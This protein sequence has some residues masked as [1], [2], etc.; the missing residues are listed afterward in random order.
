MSPVIV[1]LLMSRMLLNYN[2]SVV[3]LSIDDDGQG[4]V[5]DGKDSGLGLRSMQERAE[6]L[7]GK[8]TIESA[9][10]QGTRLMSTVPVNSSKEVDTE[11]L[12]WINL[13]R[14]YWLTIMRL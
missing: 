10:G 7:G 3:R 4:F 11:V 2:Q 6:S 5:T 8:L 9:L 13:S 14:Y 1:K 12:S